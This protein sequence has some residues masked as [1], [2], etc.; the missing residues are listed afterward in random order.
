MF[1]RN[2]TE[3]I[4]D[5]R[6]ALSFGLSQQNKCKLMENLKTQSEDIKNK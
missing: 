6:S 5:G 1:G 3:M 4:S 2:G